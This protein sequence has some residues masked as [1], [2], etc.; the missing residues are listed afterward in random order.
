MR[1]RIQPSRRWKSLRTCAFV[2][3]ALPRTSSGDTSC[4]TFSEAQRFHRPKRSSDYGSGLELRHNKK[5][6]AN[7][8]RVFHKSDDQVG[9]LESLHEPRANFVTRKGASNAT[10]HTQDSAKGDGFHPRHRKARAGEAPK[11]DAGN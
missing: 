1:R 2:I 8:H 4:D 6:P 9:N 3:L 7:C 10:H 11:N 5:A